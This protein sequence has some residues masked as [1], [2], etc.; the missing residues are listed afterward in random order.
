MMD[1]ILKLSM[2]SLNHNDSF[3]IIFV[4]KNKKMEVTRQC[5]QASL[6]SKMYVEIL[7]QSWLPGEN[8]AYTDWTCCSD[9]RKEN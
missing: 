8:C 9:L 6:V 4:W 2:M 3:V 5:L 7:W 1:Q